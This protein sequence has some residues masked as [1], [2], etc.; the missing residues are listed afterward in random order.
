MLDQGILNNLELADRVT[1]STV[2]VDIY[3]RTL[4]RREMIANE[5]S[6][7]G[8]RPSLW[9]RLT[10]ALADG[11]RLVEM[12]ITGLISIWPIVLLLGG[13]LWLLWRNNR[14]RK[15]ERPAP[16]VTPAPPAE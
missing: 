8:Y 12:A 7:E 2:T 3:Q 11:W 4:I 14:K 13:S 9:S 6:I 1:Y 5:R 15:G 16:T 10:D